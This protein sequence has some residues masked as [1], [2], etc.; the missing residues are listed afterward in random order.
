[1]LVGAEHEDQ[2]CD[3]V[4]HHQKFLGRVK[5]HG[6]IGGQRNRQAFLVKLQQWVLGISQ[7]QAV[8]AE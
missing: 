4:I 2:G 1:M 5:L 8:V 7:E 6:V 3:S